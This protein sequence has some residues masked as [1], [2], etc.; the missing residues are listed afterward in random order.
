MQHQSLVRK[1]HS[2]A[3]LLE[4]SQ[5]RFQSER[6]FATPTIHPYTFDILHNQMRTPA[7]ICATV[8]QTGNV[9]VYQVSQNLAFTANQQ[10]VF[11]ARQGT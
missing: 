1:V 9:R 5:S 4:Q 8:Q 7:G 3:N 11:W 6:L 2:S 10:F